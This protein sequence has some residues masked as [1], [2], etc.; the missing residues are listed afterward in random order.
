[1]KELHKKYI[2]VL[3]LVLNLLTIITGAYAYSVTKDYKMSAT[4]FIYAI[5]INALYYSAKEMKTKRQ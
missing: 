2:L 3:L 5:G 4:F 1:M